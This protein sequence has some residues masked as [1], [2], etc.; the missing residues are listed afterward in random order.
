MEKEFMDKV[1]KELE[2]EVRKREER[3]AEWC[4]LVDRGEDTFDTFMILPSYTQYAICEGNAELEAFLRACLGEDEYSSAV[5]V[6]KMKQQLFEDY[7]YQME[8][9]EKAR[10]DEFQSKCKDATDILN[11]KRKELKQ[12]AK[13]YAELVTQNIDSDTLDDGGEEKL[14]RELNQVRQQYDAIRDVYWCAW[15]DLINCSKNIE[16]DAKIYIDNAD[17]EMK[18]ILKHIVKVCSE[19]ISK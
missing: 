7:K 12:A 9:A 2:E 3:K 11:K 1:K 8:A 6:Y 4:K 19:I 14:Y 15:F 5:A 13:S 10:L 17:S 16:A 18:P